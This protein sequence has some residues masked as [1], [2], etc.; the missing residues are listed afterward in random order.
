MKQNNH[1]SQIDVDAYA[2]YIG[3]QK[4]EYLR[5]MAEVLQDRE[6]AHI[7]STFEGG[8]VAEMLNSIVPL[9]RN[10][11]INTN[12]YC[13]EGDKSFY[14]ITKRFH[15]II[16]GVDQ[17]FT[18]EDLFDIYIK[19]NQKNFEN[20]VIK[21]DFTVVHDPQPCASIIHGNYDSKLIWRCHIDT[22]E[23]NELIWNFLL[24][25]IN[26]Y[27]GVIFS[28]KEFVKAGIKKPVYQISPAIDPLTFKNRQRTHEEA[29]DTL[30]PLLK[31]Y[32]I[33]PE[34]PIIL[35]VSRYDIHK[36]Q[37]TIIEAFKKLNRDKKIKALKPQLIL[38]GNS[39]DDDPEGMEMYQDILQ[40]INGNKDIYP[41]LNI[42]DNDK[43]IGAL[44]KLA[45]VFIHVSTKE[46]FGL[47]V[48]EA[49][50]Q[51]TP[52]IGSSVGGIVTQV[53]PGKTGY[54]VGPMDTDS[55]VSHAKHLLLEKEERARMGTQAVEHVR[56][57]FLIT[58]LVEKYIKLMR[59]QLGIDYPYFKILPSPHR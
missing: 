59:F 43:N 18:L 47:V 2:E 55:I 48:T 33:D 35:A 53:L 50:W 9:A 23:A 56:E 19:T 34:R 37:K 15:N 29:L 49:L 20:I 32:Q 45:K 7:N 14:S 30:D 38:V 22:S 8:G 10:L 31:E 16:Q 27:D 51:G 12:W 44:M 40:V 41:L 21:E 6:W 57:N 52:V 13:I 24:P 1:L 58:G 28:M 42:P 26:N 46:G 39:A 5:S 11:G 4:V 17:K 3:N 54:L 25:Y 36:N